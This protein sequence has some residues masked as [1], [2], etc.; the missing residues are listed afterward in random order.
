MRK[1]RS[2]SCWNKLTGP[3]R[4]LLEK[5][6]FDEH[7]GYEVTLERVRSQ[8]GLEAT[9]MSLSRLYRRRLRERQVEE[10]VEAQAMS[11]AVAAPKLNTG[12]MRS[13]AIKLI[14]KI[15]LKLACERPEQLKELESMA[16]ILL[17]SE[18]NDI[19]QGRLK[20][21]QARLQHETT[22]DISDEIPKL[23]RLLVRIE[24]DDDLS[25]EAKMDRVR[26]L[27]FPLSARTDAPKSPPPQAGANT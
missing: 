26:A 14:A 5:W 11:E 8:F 23:A 16:K 4:E 18:D 22:S 10:L 7:L 13:A 1:P 15:A 3:Q 9:A 21:E 25:D 17:F 2:N 6:L 27:L 20:L 24:E 19:R 12:A